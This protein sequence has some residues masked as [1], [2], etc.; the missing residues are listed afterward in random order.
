MKAI[1]ANLKHI[2]PMIQIYTLLG[3]L[4]AAVVIPVD[5]STLLIPLI[6]WLLL[7]MGITVFNSYYDEDKDPVAGLKNPPPVNKSMF[8]ASVLYYVLGFIIAI[9]INLT[10]VYFYTLCAVMTILYSHKKVRLKSDGN[11]ALT[12]NF[13]VGVLTF[14]AVT[15]FNQSADLYL[16]VLGMFTCGS[17]LAGIYAMM[18]VHQVREDLERNDISFAAKHGRRATILLS[19]A[20]SLVASILA[21]YLLL[22]S[23][24]KLLFSLMLAIAFFSIFFLVIWSYKKDDTSVTDFRMMTRITNFITISSTIVLFLALILPI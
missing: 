24:S 13:L 7:S 15:S 11:I 1:I 12:V 21:L 5:P 6:S 20:L 19:I 14:A 18:Q 9:T 22:M 2:R 4:F 10:F 8:W 23:I 16:M 3:F 17:F